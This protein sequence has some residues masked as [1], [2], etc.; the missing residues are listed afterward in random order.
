MPVWGRL[1]AFLFT[2]V[3]RSRLRLASAP[4]TTGH[5]APRHVAYYSHVLQLTGFGS[6]T[7][8]TCGRCYHHFEQK[9][10]ILPIRYRNA[11]DRNFISPHHL[12]DETDLTTGYTSHNRVF[13]SGIMWRRCPF[14]S[15]L[16][17][18]VFP[19]EGAVLALH[20][21]TYWIPPRRAWSRTP[22]SHGCMAGAFTDQA[23]RGVLQC[24]VN[25]PVMAK[26]YRELPPFW[27]GIINFGVRMEESRF[28]KGSC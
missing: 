10:L 15:L 24:C 8:W 20:A 16:L 1:V 11:Q 6:P 7:N 25:L 12:N 17:G 2:S 26:Q 23:A 22:I 14:A 18:T 28:T 3:T 13:K 21:G 19:H 4:P 5:A 27:W 9:P